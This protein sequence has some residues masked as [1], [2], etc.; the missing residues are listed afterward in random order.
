MITH[1]VMLGAST[2]GA[3]NFVANIQP[4]PVIR[5]EAKSAVLSADLSVAYIQTKQS[6][7]I[8]VAGMLAMDTLTGEHLWN[9][10][11]DYATANH[12]DDGG[13]TAIDS[14][15]NIITNFK[16]Q[17]TV[18]PYALKMLIWKL[19]SSG[20]EQWQKELT[21]ASNYIGA[22]VCDASDNI[23]VSSLRNISGNATVFTKLNSSGAHQYSKYISNSGTSSMAYDGDTDSIHLVNHQN[24]GDYET[25]HLKIDPAGTT[26]WVDAYTEV[27]G[28]DI[29]VAHLNI[30]GSVYLI[31][32][33]VNA[34]SVYIAWWMV[35]NK[36]TG[37]ISNEGTITH[38][39][40]SLHVDTGCLDAD[41][42]IYLV[43]RSGGA[44]RFI[45]KLNSSGTLQWATRLEFKSVIG[46]VIGV[47]AHDGDTGQLVIA[48]AGNCTVNYASFQLPLVGRLADDGSGLGS[49]TYW[50]YTDATSEFTAAS[51]SS[52][53]GT[54]PGWVAT[55]TSF[56][57]SSKLSPTDLTYTEYSEDLT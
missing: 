53:A 55:T 27:S 22:M 9:K 47:I 17:Q 13:K 4:D 24:G 56:A 14:S 30:N 52:G 43:L 1:K 12:R 8:D 3:S 50:D 34:A 16:F 5:I 15:G 23:Y 44:D 10:S 45:V 11:L 39:S 57:T 51:R 21:T 42:N 25:R 28:A 32:G 36:A 54:N 20:T 40:L 48:G 26:D 6:S 41:G 46:T 37:T 7:D 49:Y 29:D 19:N 38:D 18:S 31:S 2:G 35:M 33:R